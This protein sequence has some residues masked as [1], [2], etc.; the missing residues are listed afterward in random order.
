MQPLA[1]NEF[2]QQDL[3]PLGVNVEFD[4]VEWN[5]LV[6]NWRQPRERK[7]ILLGFGAYLVMRVWTFAYFVPEITVFTQMSPRMKSPTSSRCAPLSTAIRRT[8]Q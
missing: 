7:L 4:V 1:M 6:L 8:R 5:T 2:L 3:R